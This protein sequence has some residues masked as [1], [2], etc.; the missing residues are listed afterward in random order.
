[1]S[2]SAAIAIGV[3]TLLTGLVAG[4]LAS[5]AVG[6]RRPW[7][8]VL[9]FVLLT[10]A[11]GGIFAIHATPAAPLGPAT[12]VVA[13]LAALATRRLIGQRASV[14]RSSPAPARPSQVR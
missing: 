2:G 8:L 14:A 1:M 12:A 9:V 6:T 13:I 11:T 4:T 3:A 5:I 10:G 7:L